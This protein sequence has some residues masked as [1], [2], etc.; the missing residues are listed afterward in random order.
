MEMP[1]NPPIL[2][3]QNARD[4]YQPQCCV[5]NLFS[6]NFKKTDHLLNLGLV[7]T[8]LFCEKCFIETFSISRQC[9]GC[10]QNAFSLQ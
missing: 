6:N 9:P 7:C 3:R 10:R 1:V 4:Q 5:C 2:F 8:C